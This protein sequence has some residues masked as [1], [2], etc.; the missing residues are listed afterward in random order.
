[1][2]TSTITS[3]FIVLSLSTLL[4]AGCSAPKGTSLQEKRD[5]SLSMLDESLE[6]LYKEK[7]EQREVIANAAGYGAF[8]NFGAHI[9]VL[10]TGNGYGVVVDN[11]T[12]ARTY[13]RMAE[14]G[15]GLG[16]G[17]KDFRAVF[18]FYDRETLRKFIDTG[19]EFG[20]EADAAAKAGETGGAVAAAGT[21]SKGMDIYQFTKN[22]LALQITVSGTKYWKDK[23]LN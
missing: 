16:L 19:W 17:L 7:P 21:A 20:A 23:E 12:E 15:V 18:I 2:N 6:M 11:D 4:F 22:G 5:Y 13:M 14:V 9:F 8:S 3:R 10:S 1:M